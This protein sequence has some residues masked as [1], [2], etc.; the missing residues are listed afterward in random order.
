MG[1]G[2]RFSSL[3]EPSRFVIL[4]SILYTSTVLH[5][6]PFIYNALAI[7]THLLAF[8]KAPVDARATS[9]SEVALLITTRAFGYN[10][11]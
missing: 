9:I 4:V 1:V 10:P 7:I 3:C 8:V 5:V 6:V 11:Q 2:V